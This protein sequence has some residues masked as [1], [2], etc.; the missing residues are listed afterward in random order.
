MSRENV[1]YTFHFCILDRDKERDSL[2][3]RR[4]GHLSRTKTFNTKAEAE[5]CAQVTESEMVRGDFVSRKEAENTTLAET[6]DRYL[7]E[8][9]SKKREPIRNLAGSK[10]S[11]VTISPKG[12]LPQSRGNTSPNNGTSVWRVFPRPPFG[13]NWPFSP[14]CSIRPSG[15]GG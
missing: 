14:T 4:K 11:K 2:R 15:N 7:Q 13:L 8:V 12:I 5:A 6:L 3:V 1:K 9:S 10:I